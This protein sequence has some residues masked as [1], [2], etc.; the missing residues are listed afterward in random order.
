MKMYCAAVVVT[1]GS[2]SLIVN[3]CM[4]RDTGTRHAPV[5]IAHLR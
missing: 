2:V 1:I 5:N 3:T 4:F